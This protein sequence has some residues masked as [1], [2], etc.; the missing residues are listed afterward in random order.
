M[1]ALDKLARALGVNTG[2]LVGRKPVARQ[3]GDAL[4]GAVLALD[5]VAARKAKQLTQESLSEPSGV[6]RAVIAHIERQTRNP[7]LLTLVKLA[8]SLGLSLEAL[9]TD[10]GSKP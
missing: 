4:I 5:L 9:L 3:D 2:S 6:G 10:S 8:A 1:N 7:S